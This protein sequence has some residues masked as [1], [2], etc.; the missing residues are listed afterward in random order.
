VVGDLG[1]AVVGDVAD[2]CCWGVVGVVGVAFG[3]GEGDAVEAVVA[4]AHT[5]DAG[6]GLV[7]VG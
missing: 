4:D 3:G 7:V 2:D 1:C 5:D 6:F